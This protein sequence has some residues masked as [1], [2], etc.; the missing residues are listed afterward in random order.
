MELR[1]RYL[2]CLLGLAVCDALGAPVEKKKRGSFTLTEMIAGRDDFDH[3]LGEWT[4]DTA[5]AL[6]LAESLLER[7]G[8]DPRDLLGRWLRWWREGALSAAGHC[9]GIGKTTRAALARFEQEGTLYAPPDE[10]QQGNGPLMRVAPVALWAMALEPADPKAAL[11]LAMDQAAL[12]HGGKIAAEAAA[13][14]VHYLCQALRGQGKA[15]ILDPIRALGALPELWSRREGE[16]DELARVLL[17]DYLALPAEALSSSWGPSPCTLRNAL[18]A[19]WQSSD[20]RS[21]ALAAV[22]LGEDADTVGAIYGALAGAFYG[23]NGIPKPW[24]EKVL[25]RE[26]IASYAERLLAAPSGRTAP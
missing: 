25:Q 18:W 14:F 13:L 21:G 12:T 7:Q 22:N 3:Q 8:Y 5:M 6:G 11:R 23:I 19:F 10:G 16:L 26:L 2:G 17:Q 24:L 1:E 9:V 15:E 20:F 4:D